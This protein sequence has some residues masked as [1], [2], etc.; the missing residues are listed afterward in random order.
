M[1]IG[2]IKDFIYQTFIDMS[3]YLLKLLFAWNLYEANRVNT[4][5]GKKTVFTRSAITL[6]KVNQFG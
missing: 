5:W 6:P 4:L 1:K 3:K 2:D